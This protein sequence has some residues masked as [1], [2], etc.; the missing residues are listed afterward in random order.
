MARAKRRFVCQSCGHESSQW[1][2]RCPACEQWD[3]FV[4]EVVAAPAPRQATPA[5]SVLAP[6]ALTEVETADDE[7][8][9]TASNELN[10]VLGGGIMR[11]SFTLI[12]GDPGIGKSTLM[13]ELAR[14]AEGR[15]VLYVSGEESVAQVKSRAIR[16]G[17]RGDNLLLLAETDVN[18][19]VGAMVDVEPDLLVVDSI[20]TVFRPEIGSAPGS[21]AQVRESAGALLNAT[22]QRDIAAFVVGHVTKD[23]SI[24]GPRVLEHMVDTV[25]YFE[26]DRHH[27]YRILRAVKNRFGSANEIGVFEMRETGLA[28]V[29]DPSGIFL[30]ERRYGVSGSTVVAAMEGSRPVL[31]EVQALVTPTSYGTPQRSATGLDYRRLQML[32]AVLEKRHGLRLA[33]HDVFV[34]V[35]GGMRLEEPAADLAVAAA[36]ASSFR[37]VPLD[38]GTVVL[39]EIGLGGEVRTV[40]RLE[41]RLNES[42]RLGF[43]RA[44]VPA[45]G[46][47]SVR[48]P[49][50]LEVTGVDSLSKALDLLI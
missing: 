44:L 5:R 1:M 16:L 37:D 8:I 4:E 22:K 48:R 39:G 49:A 12:A 35:A 14:H 38:S 21:V 45:A 19:I 15:R 3:T 2:G 41:A 13:T 31:V 46:L 7:R 11:G 26:G 43:A 24:A 25:L 23:G 34:N 50:G 47:S 30:S 29:S 33:A 17:V 28:E 6:L 20:Q 10:R 36:V 27:A 9:R 18:A 42:A 32:L 40:S